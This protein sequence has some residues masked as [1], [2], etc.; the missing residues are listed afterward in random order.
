MDASAVQSS[1]S[2]IRMADWNPNYAAQWS[3]R[4]AQFKGFFESSGIDEIDFFLTD[5]YFPGLIGGSL[6]IAHSDVDVLFGSAAASG[7][8]LKLM[9][10]YRDKEWW[11]M[12]VGEGIETFEDLKGGK[13]SGGGLGGRNTWIQRQILIQNGIDPDTD[14]E[15][16]PM[17]GG[18]DGRMK[19]VIA[20]VLQGAS[21]FPRHEKGL[22]DNGGKFLSARKVEVPQEGFIT[23]MEWGAKNE[24]AL[25][26][27]QYAELKARLWLHD[28]S[29][30]EAAYSEMR[31]KGFEIPPEFEAQYETELDQISKDGGFSAESMDSFAQGVIDL[32]QVPGNFDWRDHVDLRFLHAAQ[33]SLGIPRRPS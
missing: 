11:I 7:V 29:N 5:T 33:D 17:K 6:D 23:N 25:Y 27:W 31:A 15:M 3:W 30:K 32:G 22:K 8:P 19:A 28:R 26:A 4:L 12:G 18:S 10:I 2:K 21:V 1:V 9:S 24:D 13:I 16:V 14:V 20:G